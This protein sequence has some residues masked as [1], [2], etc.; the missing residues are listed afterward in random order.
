MGNDQGWRRKASW[1]AYAVL[2]TAGWHDVI[3]A[4]RRRPW[5]Q[6]NTEIRRKIVAMVAAE[7]RL[8]A[9]MTTLEI[10]IEKW[11]RDMLCMCRVSIT[12]SSMLSYLLATTYLSLFIIVAAF[13]RYGERS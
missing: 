1:W 9:A 12:E 6:L 4:H 2:I 13:C 5:R 10:G 7:T 8:R 11:R 3:I